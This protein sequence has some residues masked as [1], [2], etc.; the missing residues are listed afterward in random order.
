MALGIVLLAAA[1]LWGGPAADAQG[2]ADEG[3]PAKARKE[4]PV[5]GAAAPSFS[6]T[7]MEGKRYTLGQFRGKPVL[8]NFWASWCGPCRAEAPSLTR[9]QQ[10]YGSELQIV[11]VNLT[12]ADDERAARRFVSRYGFTFPVLLDPDGEAASRYRIRP[13]PTSL[14]IGADGVIRDVALGALDWDNLVSRTERL[15][16][17]QG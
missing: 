2:S 6:L 12:A 3:L 4:A 5:I 7:G 16:H 15:L 17:P 13:I 1:A 9:L 10:K 8:L 14:F 11:A